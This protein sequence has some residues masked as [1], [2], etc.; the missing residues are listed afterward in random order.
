MGNVATQLV[1]AAGGGRLMVAPKGTV[2]PV[3]SQAAWGQGWID[4][5][6]IAE[7]GLGIKP[8]ARPRRRLGPAGDV[9]GRGR[10]QRDRLPADE[11]PG[12]AAG[13]GTVVAVT[14]GSG[15]SSSGQTVKTRWGD[16]GNPEETDGSCR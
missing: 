10:R 5:G 1:V 15:G 14:A 8:E 11:R 2:A 3:D 9:R 4:L 13:V 12:A 7:D 6:Y 16:S